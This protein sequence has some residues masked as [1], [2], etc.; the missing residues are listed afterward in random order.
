MTSKYA[1]GYF[2]RILDFVKT[3]RMFGSGQKADITEVV[4][5]SFL[6]CSFQA[7]TSGPWR[8]DQDDFTYDTRHLQPP[9]SA[10][11]NWRC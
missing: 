9:I 1:E 10:G 11:R 3:T 6:D 4:R 2:N 7:Q 8:R 5:E